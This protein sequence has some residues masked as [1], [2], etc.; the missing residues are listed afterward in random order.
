MR[1]H[2][3]VAKQPKLAQT[4]WSARRTYPMHFPIY[5]ARLHLPDI[6]FVVLYGNN[7]SEGNGMLTAYT[8]RRF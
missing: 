8:E 6:D 1:H 5:A 3:K 2:E 7:L 4:G